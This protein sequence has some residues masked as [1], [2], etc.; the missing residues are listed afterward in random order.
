[1]L[2]FNKFNLLLC[3]DRKTVFD[4]LESKEI[5]YVL[6]ADILTILVIEPTS[7]DEMLFLFE[8]ENVIV[9]LSKTDAE[10]LYE[11]YDF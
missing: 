2:E 6:I 9:E 10:I 7:I 3:D 11:K 1:M 8:T 5:E 4:F